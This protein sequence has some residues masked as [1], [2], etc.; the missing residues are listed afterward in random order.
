MPQFTVG[1]YVLVARIRRVGSHPKL[2]SKWVG[3]WRV[4]ND[5]KE[6][7]YTIEV[8]VTGK[9][10]DVHVVRI[11]FYADWALEVDGPLQQL[12]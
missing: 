1:D 12:F 4:V 6:H 3:P 9:T 7:V 11:R 8:I 5:D 10:R 2:M